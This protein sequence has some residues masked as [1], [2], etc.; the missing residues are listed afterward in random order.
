[1][2]DYAVI[3]AVGETLK[4]LLYEGFRSDPDIGIDRSEIHFE[5]PSKFL[6]ELYDPLEEECLSIY[7]YRIVENGDM[8]NR[9]PELRA[10]N[11]EHQS[12]YPPLSLNLYYLITPLTCKAAD[13]DSRILGKAM[14]IFNDHGILAGEDLQGV[15]ANT[16]EELRLTLDP[17]SIEDMMRIWGG[18]MRPYRLSVSYEVKVVYID[19]ERQRTVTPVQSRQLAFTP[20]NGGASP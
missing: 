13:K 20:V 10:L 11:S 18:F 8:K 9:L 15:L 14:Q 4:E 1:M 6:G 5:P 7:L 19:S 17:I 12:Q 3:K 2:G 16:T